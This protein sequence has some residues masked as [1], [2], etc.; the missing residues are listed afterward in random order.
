MTYLLWVVGGLVA[1]GIIGFIW[2]HWF[3]DDD[4]DEYQEC[5]YD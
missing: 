3:A 4:D 2:C 1:W 5:P